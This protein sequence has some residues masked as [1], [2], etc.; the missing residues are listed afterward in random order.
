MNEPIR[1]SKIGLL[2]IFSAGVSGDILRNCPRSEYIKYSSMGATVLFTALLAL[3]SSYFAFS[4][5]FSADWLRWMLAIFWAAIIFNLDRYIISSM[6]KKEK[7]MQEWLQA[8]PRL[9]LAGVIAM[10]I[11]KPLEL[12]LFESEINQFLTQ[13]KITQVAA[14]EKQYATQLVAVEQAKEGL[15]S[16]LQLQFDMRERYYQEY[17]CEC[18][19]TCG[20]GIRGSGS[21]CDRKREKY[22]SFMREYNQHKIQVEAELQLWSQR[23]ATINEA[24]TAQKTAVVNSFSEGLLARLDALSKLPGMA[25]FAIMLIFLLIETAPVVTKLLSSKGPYDH[26]LQQAEYEYKVQ[27]LSTVVEKNENFHRNRQLNEL[28]TT[29]HLKE[30]AAELHAQ[31]KAKALA[32]QKKLEME[33]HKILTRS[34]R[35]TSNN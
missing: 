29:M 7:P 19:G 27:Y 11:A 17:K 18:D 1:A 16:T 26:L 4:L 15:K 10:V 9:L 22:E 34:N 21:E 12:K 6:R 2:L 5:I 32:K 14:V 8:F 23:G 30:K 35:D 20:T 25:S 13:D 28:E 31:Q 24:A 3:L 33:L